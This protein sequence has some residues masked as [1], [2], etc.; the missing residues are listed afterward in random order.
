M[1]VQINRTNRMPRNVLVTAVAGLLMTGL[2]GADDGV[3]ASAPREQGKFAPDRVLIR[4]KDGTPAAAKAKARDEAMVDVS[5]EFDF[6]PGLQVATLRR[7]EKVED[8]IAR[9][10]KNPNVAYAEPDYLQRALL[11]VDQPLQLGS[12]DQPVRVREGL[13]EHHLVGPLRRDQPPA[14]QE[15]PVQQRLALLGDR[16]DPA[17][18]RLGK[19]GRPRPAPAGEARSR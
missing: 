18:H 5:A 4:F 11:A 15:E 13:R 1:E 6:V 7:N 9:L 8:V 17:H 10:S 12:G 16:D 14:H 3:A 19:T 2:A